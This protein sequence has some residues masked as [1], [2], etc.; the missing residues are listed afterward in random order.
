MYNLL[1]IHNNITFAWDSNKFLSR[2]LNNE[3]VFI[4]ASNEEVIS[5]LDKLPIQYKVFQSADVISIIEYVNKF[6]GVVFYNL[7]E[8]KVQILLHINP[9]V[10]TFLRFFGYELYGITPEKF[11]SIKTWKFFSIPKKS[12]LGQLKSLYLLLK[13]K[14]R[15]ALNKEYEVQMDNQKQ[16]YS[17]LDAVMMLSPFEYQ[18][19][20]RLFYLPPLIELKFTN[21]AKEIHQFKANVEKENKVIVGNSGHRWNNHLDILDIISNIENK[22]S[23]GFELFFSYGTESIYSQ[24]VKSAAQKIK[25][26]RLIENFLSFAEFDAV[27]SSAAALV[28]NSYRQH[29]TGNIFT[30][31]KYGCKI[32]LS[33]RNSIYH[34]LVAE[35]FLISEVDSLMA[36]L[37]SGDIKLTTE[38]QHHN[39]DCYM[40]VMK[41]YTIDDL[42]ASVI[43]VLKKQKSLTQ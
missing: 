26:V 13:R 30:A 20:S 17:R 8:I 6:D 32:Y 28:I 29:A 12:T 35:G 2:E 7:D 41:N 43:S 24:N 34:W 16:V 38:Q 40:S 22:N 36:D 10:K 1:H 42:V 21:H 33:K 37:E 5:K 39:Y 25:S 19:L 31:F 18:E 15:I 11:L 23:I 9:C 27:Y 3:I 4:G 14:V